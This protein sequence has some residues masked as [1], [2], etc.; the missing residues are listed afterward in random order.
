MFRIWLEISHDSQING[1]SLA[2]SA[3]FDIDDDCYV[4][5]DSIGRNFLPSIYHWNRF[6]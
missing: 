5:N 6:S 2:H 1:P 3:C 4:L